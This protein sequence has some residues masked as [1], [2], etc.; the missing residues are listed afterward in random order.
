METEARKRD[1]EYKQKSKKAMKRKFEGEK[2]E[3]VEEKKDESDSMLN[4]V[5]QT[6]GIPELCFWTA[7]DSTIY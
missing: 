1:I 7:R 3:E 6:K 5:W 2:E 4:P